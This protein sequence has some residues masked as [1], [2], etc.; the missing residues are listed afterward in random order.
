MK[1]PTHLGFAGRGAVF[2]VRSL[3]EI[4]SIAVLGRGGLTSCVRPVEAATATRERRTDENHTRDSP[5]TSP[6][7]GRSPRMLTS[8]SWPRPRDRADVTSRQSSLDGEFDRCAQG[9]S[10]DDLVVAEAVRALLA[11]GTLGMV[12]CVDVEGADPGTWLLSRLEDGRWRVLPASE[13]VWAGGRSREKAE[14]PP[15]GFAVAFPRGGHPV[16]A[17]REATRIHVGKVDWVQPGVASVRIDME[18]GVMCGGGY[19]ASLARNADGSW[20]IV[21]GQ[22]G[23]ISRRART[24]AEEARAC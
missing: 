23:P 20:R 15:P 16:D 12:A 22:V 2:Q 3:R 13:C 10:E 9:V 11:Q 17:Q 24:P 18:C 21:L 7:H 8:E 6:E 5:D 14:S 19:R 1:F 4:R